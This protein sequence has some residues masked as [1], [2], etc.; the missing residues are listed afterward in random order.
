MYNFFFLPIES[1]CSLEHNL[2][3]S[4]FASP[5]KGT[6]DYFSA[7]SNNANG[8]GKDAATSAA[9]NNLVS[10][11]LTTANASLDMASFKSFNCQMPR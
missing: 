2:P 9:N 10:S 4:P 3:D 5:A 8:I 1:C 11:N 6:G 7:F